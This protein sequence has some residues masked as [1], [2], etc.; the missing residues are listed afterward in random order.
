MC[1]ICAN[2][3]HRW[4]GVVRAMCRWKAQIW[5]LIRGSA[6]PPLPLTQMQAPFTGFH[7]PEYVGTM[8]EERNRYFVAFLLDP[9]TQ[10]SSFRIQSPW[11]LHV[12]H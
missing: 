1:A 4:A 11:S 9:F 10:S 8:V 3:T 6:R 2:N 12:S 7:A 5:S